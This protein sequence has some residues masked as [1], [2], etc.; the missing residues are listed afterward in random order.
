MSFEEFA[1]ACPP[2]LLPFAGVVT[3]GR[4][5]AEVVQEVLIRAN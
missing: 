4:G 5:V 2:A 3:G 1:V